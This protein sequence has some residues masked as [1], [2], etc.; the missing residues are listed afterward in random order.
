MHIHNCKVDDAQGTGVKILDEAGCT[1]DRF[2]MHDLVYERM[3]QILRAYTETHAFKFADRNTLVFVCEISLC[4][5]QEPG[6]S[7]LSVG[8]SLSDR[9]C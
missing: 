3:G 7:Q 2:V 4:M 6:C 1:T 9:R 5:R 8:V